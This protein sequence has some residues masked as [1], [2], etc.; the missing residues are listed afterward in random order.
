MSG[1][2]LDATNPFTVSFLRALVR[3]AERSGYH[4]VAFTHD[5]DAERFV[6][7]AAGGVVDGFVLSDSPMD[8]RRA[9][10]LRDA[11]I[12][13][14]T[15]GRT[16]PDLPQNWVDIDNRAAIAAA[17]DHLVARG[18]RRFAYVG[19][20][21]GYYWDTDRYEGTRDRLAAHGLELP[22]PRCRFGRPQDLAPSVAELLTQERPD[23]VVTSSDAV[24]VVVVNA[25]HSVGV[26]VGSDLAVTGFDAGPLRT[27][28]TPHLT[29]VNIPVDRIA[30]ELIRLTVGQLEGQPPTGGLLVPTDLVIGAST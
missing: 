1:E 26:A 23:A 30:T 15:F 10:V 17:V 14:V 9:R 2:Q 7:T 24:A 12:P 21:L 16:A 28:V 6:T 4:V 5:H 18:R 11:G 3:A 20:P 8:D 25:A 19:Y 29:S 13:F 22:E 27:L